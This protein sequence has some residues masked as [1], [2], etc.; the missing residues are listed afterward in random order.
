MKYNLK[1]NIFKK[2]S[3]AKQVEFMRNWFSER[4]EDPAHGTPYDSSEG[5]YQWIYG[6]PY[7][8]EEILDGNFAEFAKKGAIEELSEE[9]SY[10]CSHW[11]RTRYY[12]DE[13]YPDEEDWAFD[14]VFEDF[15]IIDRAKAS[16]SSIEKLLGKRKLA[17]EEKKFNE[18][19][20]FSFC[21]TIMETYLS[22]IFLRVILKNVDLKKKYLQNDKILSKTNISLGEL[23]DKYDKVDA[24]MRDR[25]H[26]TSFHNLATVKAIFNTVLGI[27]IGDISVLSKYVEKRHDFVH[28]GGKS[29]EGQP[30]ST[31]EKEIKE[32]VRLVRR[33]CL[34]LDSK[35]INK[36]LI[37]VS[38]NE[39]E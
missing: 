32:L 3:K 27:D 5:G 6:G 2:K 28:R 21:I 37:K 16:L 20:T 12:D 7:D 19:M 13:L 36:K 30:V 26:N 17:Y 29:K 33:C 18:M 35:I 31:S 11:T 25:I 8:A 14:L 9:L 1:I 22:D 10:E 38:E 4:F 15:Q 24:I 39:I 34:D 23:F